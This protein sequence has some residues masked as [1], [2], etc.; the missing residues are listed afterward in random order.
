M[1]VKQLQALHNS[2]FAPN[3]LVEVIAFNENHIHDRQVSGYILEDTLTP[4]LEPCDSLSQPL[5][6][7]KQNDLSQKL[8]KLTEE[9][10]PITKSPDLHAGQFRR[11][12]FP[13]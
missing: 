9:S 4:D 10:N 2:N 8:Q 13:S 5:C 7:V 1:C 6:T 3:V 12:W 11:S